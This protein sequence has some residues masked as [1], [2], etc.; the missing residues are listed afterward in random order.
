MNVRFFKEAEVKKEKTILYIAEDMN[1]KI[2]SP[3]NGKCKCGKCI[4]KVLSGNVSETTKSEE[5]W[6]IAISKKVQKE[7]SI[8]TN[9]IISIN[10]HK[11]FVYISNNREH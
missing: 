5:L 10:N 9:W 8:S 1:I 3:C 4:V 2:K 6:S 11:D 7:V